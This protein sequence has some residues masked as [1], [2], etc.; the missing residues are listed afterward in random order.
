MIFPKVKP[1][2]FDRSWQDA[3]GTILASVETGS[4]KQTVLIVSESGPT[5]LEALH[6][7]FH[8]RLVLA[9][10]EHP[11]RAPLEAVLRDQEPNCVIALEANQTG[12]ATH[13]PAIA[14]TPSL[15]VSSTDLEYAETGSYPAWTNQNA[16]A[17]DPQAV[18]VIASVAS[19]RGLPCFVCNPSDLTAALELAFKK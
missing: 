11:H 19:N 2:E 9:V 3:F 5:V 14:G 7:T 13:G 10:L 17:S 12:I 18:S 8:G 15:E 16:A 4:R 1:L 6:I